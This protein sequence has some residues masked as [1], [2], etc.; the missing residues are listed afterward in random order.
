M[1]NKNK[2]TSSWRLVIEKTAGVKRKEKTKKESMVAMANLNLDDRDAK[3][4]T[5]ITLH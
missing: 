5:T 2:N 3:R 1:E 4:R